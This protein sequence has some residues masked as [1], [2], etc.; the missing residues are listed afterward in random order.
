MTQQATVRKILNHGLAEVEVVRRG[1]CAHDCA[2]CGGC[3]G[4][5]NQTIRVTARNH[6]DAQ[7]GERVT[8][9]GENKQVLGFAAL[10]Y[11]VPLV[12]FFLGYGLASLLHKGAAIAAL[13][14]IILFAVGILIAI[15]YSRVLKEKNN[16][17]FTITSRI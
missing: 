10:V 14:G 4:M 15:R 6:A 3:D 16:V 8:I 12:L 11:A 13:G 5:A 17:T 7:V 2:K 1:A 9:E